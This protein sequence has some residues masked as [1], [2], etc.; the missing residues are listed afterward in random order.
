M[1]RAPWLTRSEV[2]EI[3]QLLA[4]GLTHRQIARRLARSIGSIARVRAGLVAGR[5]RPLTRKYYHRK[6]YRT[7]FEERR[8]SARLSRWRQRV[9]AIG[10]DV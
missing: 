8:A 9:R 1:S 10:I 2:T 3:Q 4:E 5:S 7:H 6:Y